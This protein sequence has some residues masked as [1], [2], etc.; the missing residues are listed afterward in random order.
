MGA[1]AFKIT[2]Y[3]LEKNNINKL[4]GIRTQSP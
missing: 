4:N 2:T 3:Y 1:E